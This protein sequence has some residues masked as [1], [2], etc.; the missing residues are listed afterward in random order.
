MSLEN[1]LVP[2]NYNLYAG[3][4]TLKQG[5]QSLVGATGLSGDT[6]PQGPQGLFGVTGLISNGDLA[7]FYGTAG[8]LQ[9][10]SLPASWINQAVT[11]DSSVTFDSVT[12]STNGGTPTALSYYEELPLTL[13]WTAAGSHTGS[14]S[15][16]INTIG[17]ISTIKINAF[18]FSQSVGGKVTITGLPSRF[19]ASAFSFAYLYT[20]NGTS[21]LGVATNSPSPSLSLGT[22]VNGNFS[23]TGT[24]SIGGIIF[25]YNLGV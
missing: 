21:A 6:G 23:G 12:L 22:A 7:V 10:T 13:T 19:A 20:D 25:T 2:N 1:I 17:N 11:T 3:S 5:N 24:L 16:E 8:V 9:D 4:I 14:V 15:G 18:S